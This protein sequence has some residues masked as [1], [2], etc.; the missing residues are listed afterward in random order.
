VLW[1]LG[2]TLVSGAQEALLYD[3]LVAVGAEAEYPRINGW[4]HAAVLLAGLP[5][6]IAATALFAGG[7][8]ELVG[9][10]SVGVCLAAAALAGRLPEPAPTGDEPADEPAYLAT[11]RT[12][13]AEAA[14]RPGWPP[15]RCSTSPT[16]PRSWWWTPAF[17][18]AS[19][20]DPGPP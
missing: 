20:A 12:G 11:L 13:V 2:G 3:G 14:T 4:V 9:W 17:R 18:S 15:S 7:G 19:R 10:V 8:F 1:G 6:A 5:A 16:T